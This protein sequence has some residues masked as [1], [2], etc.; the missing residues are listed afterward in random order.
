MERRVDST[1]SRGG[2]GW[3]RMTT[4]RQITSFECGAVCMGGVWVVFRHWCFVIRSYGVWRVGAE[5]GG[6]ASR[7][8]PFGGFDIDATVLHPFPTATALQHLARVA[9]IR[10]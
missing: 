2:E 6:G 5:A 10:Q 7:Y 9:R 3:V 8:N 1:P 4:P